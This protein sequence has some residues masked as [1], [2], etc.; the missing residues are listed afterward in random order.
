MKLEGFFELGGKKEEEKKGM[1][2]TLYGKVLPG[3]KLVRLMRCA[4]LFCLESRVKI[5]FALEST[6]G[7]K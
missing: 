7:N 4:D 3:K 6:K 2:N 5:S 1:K